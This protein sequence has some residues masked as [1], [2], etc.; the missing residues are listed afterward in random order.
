ML[1]I[2]HA[3]IISTI[4]LEIKENCQVYVVSKSILRLTFRD[5]NEIGL[6]DFSVPLCTCFTFFLL[7]S[8]W[9]NSISDNVRRLFRTIYW[10]IKV[11]YYCFV[12]SFTR[13][14]EI[15][16]TASLIA[17]FFL[18]LSIQVLLLTFDLKRQFSVIQADD[19]TWL[20]L[21][22]MYFFDLSGG[23][24]STQLYAIVRSVKIFGIAI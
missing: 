23:E 17:N 9:S 24:K 5:T 7:C 2:C 21:A 18:L 11:K 14:H 1:F 8:A 19:D 16:N 22:Y 3:R 10:V 15:L 6:V 13:N 4:L 20:L 12:A